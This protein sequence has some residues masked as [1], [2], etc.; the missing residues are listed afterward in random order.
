MA[1]F[2]KAKKV[3]DLDA[4]TI[5][6]D[7]ADGNG[8]ITVNVDKFN[9]EV[10]RKAMFHGV[11]QKVQDSYAST[12]TADEA[13]SAAT[14]TVKALDGGS[15]TVRTAGEGGGQLPMLVEA[16]FRVIGQAEGKTIGECAELIESMDDGQRKGCRELPPIVAALDEIRAERALEKAEKSRAAA[17]GKALDLSSIMGATA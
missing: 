16:L 15:W 2:S 10:K 7:F 4:G 11:A 12:E 3:V 14:A 13:Y 6:F 17:A 1:K 5:R 8:S 9:D